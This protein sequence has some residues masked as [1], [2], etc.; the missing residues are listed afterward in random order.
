MVL[1]LII[2]RTTSIEKSSTMYPYSEKSIPFEIHLTKDYAATSVLVVEHD[3]LLH[4]TC[5]EYDYANRDSSTGFHNY[6]SHYRV[7]IVLAFEKQIITHRCIGMRTSIRTERP[8][9]IEDG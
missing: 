4:R 9:S 3:G 1:E 8:K 2:W 6:G 7:Q 5:K